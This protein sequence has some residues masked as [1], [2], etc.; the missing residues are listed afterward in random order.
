MRKG[1]WNLSRELI[2]NYRVVLEVSHSST[3]ATA[4]EEDCFDISTDSLESNC[5]KMR[6]SSSL[7]SFETETHAPRQNPTERQDE[8][9][10]DSPESP[11]ESMCSDIFVVEESPNNEK[12]ITS[13][14]V[15]EYFDKVQ[16]QDSAF[17]FITPAGTPRKISFKPVSPL[18]D[19][20]KECNSSATGASTELPPLTFMPRQPG[21]GVFPRG[22]ALSQHAPGL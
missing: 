21:R 18:N 12:S 2:P 14:R 4:D 22:V 20:E 7:E 16:Q 19:F 3:E 1:F 17:Y 5:K 15:A 9:L 6:L 8:S 13:S 10:L 11:D